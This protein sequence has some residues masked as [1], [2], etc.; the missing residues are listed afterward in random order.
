MSDYEILDILKRFENVIEFINS[1]KDIE[2]IAD[3]V[4]KIYYFV[5][6]FGSLE[7]LTDH[8]KKIEKYIY[9]GKEIFTVEEAAAF[10]GVSVSF[11]YRLT[12]GKQISVYRPSGKLLYIN[13]NELINWVMKY[14]ELSEEKIEELGSKKIDE[15]KYTRKSKVKRL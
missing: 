13:R 2:E 15:Q 5:T 11:I 6:R 12:S 1:R 3:R 8:M 10:L 9:V 4:N 7:K 14:E